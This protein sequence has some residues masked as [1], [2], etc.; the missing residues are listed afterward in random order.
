[1]R[2]KLFH[3]LLASP[4]ISGNYKFFFDMDGTLVNTD[5]IAIQA[6][7]ITLIRMKNRHG[8]TYPVPSIPEIHS[9]IAGMTLLQAL[10]SVKNKY[11]EIKTVQNEYEKSL[12]VNYETLKRNTKMEDYLIAPAVN[13]LKMLVKQKYSV[14]IV[15]NSSRQEIEENIALF[16][17]DKPIPCV[18]RQDFSR[19]KPS[20]EPYLTAAALVKVIPD[21]YCTAFEDSENGIRS[22]KAAGMFVIGIGIHQ[23]AHKLIRWGADAT[24]SDA[25]EFNIDHLSCLL[26]HKLEHKLKHKTESVSI[27][28]KI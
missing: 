4:V 23:E 1:M 2:I 9:M 5:N 10:A 12:G 11:P 24:L 15:S 7:Q 27:R 16:N 20:P 26:E 17:L 3:V 28:A 25:S 13:L 22:A 18:G 14:C 8:L 19:G 6:H 21:Q